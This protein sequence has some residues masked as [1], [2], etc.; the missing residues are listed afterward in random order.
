[1]A[2]ITILAKLNTAIIIQPD[3]TKA[4]LVTIDEVSDNQSG[5][6]ATQLKETVR[7]QRVSKAIDT[8]PRLGDFKILPE[9]SAR[10]LLDFKP[11][12]SVEQQVFLNALKLHQDY[13][14]R[15]LFYPL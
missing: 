12:F 1:M 4:G 5:M 8:A 15:R 9:G 11:G 7:F 2:P 10:S 14:V 3:K 6:F 13:L